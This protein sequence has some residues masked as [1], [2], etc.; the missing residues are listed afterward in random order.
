MNIQVKK[1]KKNFMKLFKIALLT[2]ISVTSAEVTFSQQANYDLT[3]GNGNGLRFWSDNNY[4]IHM[5]TGAEYQYGPVTDYSIKMNM[6]NTAGRG[7]TWGIM[8]ATPV[9]ALGINGVMQI[10]GKFSTLD[11]IAVGT[12][13]SGGKISFTNV[14]ATSQGDGITWNPQ[15]AMSYGIFRTPG[16][17]T[18]PDYQQMKLTFATGIILDPGA[19]YGKSYVDVQGGGLRVTAGNVGIGTA[20]PSSKLVIDGIDNY[21]DGITIQNTG[22]YKHLITGYSDGNAPTTGSALQF[23]VANNNTGGNTPVMTLKGS[24]FVGI[25]TPQPASALSVKG[26]VGIRSDAAPTLPTETLRVEGAISTEENVVNVTNLADQ[27]F[28]VRLSAVGAATKRTI[29]G[30]SVANRFS[31][32]VGVTSG[33]EYLTIISG[34]N[35]GIANTSPQAKLHISNG[36]LLLQNPTS[37]YPTLWLKNVAG[38]NTLKLDYNSIIGAGS[39]LIVRSGSSAIVLNDVGGNVGIG[40]ANPN[41]KLTVNGTVYAKEF[42]VDLSVPGPDYV[43]EKDYRLPSLEEIKNYIDQNK[44]LP[45]VPSAKEMEANG[46]NMGEMNMILLKKIEELTLYLLDQQKQLNAQQKEIQSLKR[47][48]N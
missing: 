1:S 39:N 47:Q 35:V 37:G 21:T 41:Q 46:I 36:D 13:S 19:A 22:S 31:L 4:K 30:P 40:T 26:R 44:H 7:W 34:G 2:L 42:K 20:S 5:G 15:T 45:E 14:D 32:G 6:S 33:N 23:K 48:K 16:S 18:S 25:G 43:F 10:A 27:D 12:A 28:L 11:N 29:I 3:P 9:A 17:W 8:G 24:G 38:T